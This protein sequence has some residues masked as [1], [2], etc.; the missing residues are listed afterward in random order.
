MTIH[1]FNFSM[2]KNLKPAYSHLPVIYLNLSFL[3][4]E[5]QHKQLD[6]NYQLYKRA[7]WYLD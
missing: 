4:Q 3:S 7:P 1:F 6:N 5:K 2:S